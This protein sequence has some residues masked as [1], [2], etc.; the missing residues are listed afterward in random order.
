M[1]EEL[2]TQEEHNAYTRLALCP[3]HDLELLPDISGVVPIVKCPNPNCH[4]S[5]DIS[6]SN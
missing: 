6:A 2:L 4:I 5:Y 3:I 1:P